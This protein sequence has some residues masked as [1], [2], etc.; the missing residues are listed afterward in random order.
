M[1]VIQYGEVLISGRVADLYVI[2]RSC[3]CI[4]VFGRRATFKSGVLSHSASGDLG[5]ISQELGTI[6]AI[7]SSKVSGAGGLLMIRTIYASICGALIFLAALIPP[8]VL[9]IDRAMI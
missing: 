2:D 9:I 8:L 7:R 4:L 5:L 1:P 6:A 3:S